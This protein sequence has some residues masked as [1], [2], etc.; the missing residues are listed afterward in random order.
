MRSNGLAVPV[1]FRLVTLLLSTAAFVPPVLTLQHQHQ[2][3][4]RDRFSL[5]S[6]SS[7]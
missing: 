3:A 1:L 5:Y 4:G 6:S 2:R 7:D